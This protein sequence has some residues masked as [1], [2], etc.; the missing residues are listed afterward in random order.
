MGLDFCCLKKC[1]TQQRLSLPVHIASVLIHLCW[2]D[3][4]K[5][6]SCP[7]TIRPSCMGSVLV[8]AGSLW[9]LVVNQQQ[10]A[11]KIKDGWMD[12]QD[13]FFH[14]EKTSS[15]GNHGSWLAQFLF[16]CF[17]TTNN[18]LTLTHVLTICIWYTYLLVTCYSAYLHT[19]KI[20]SLL[21]RL[22]RWNPVST[23][24]GFIHNQ[25]IH[26]WLPMDDSVG[27]CWFILCCNG[28]YIPI[29]KT[30]FGNDLFN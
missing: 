11:G 10:P 9:P 25:I 21:D 4:W 24:L 18:P 2:G 14:S 3:Q 26:N 30:Y 28:N 5:D 22:P 13:T 29:I 27:I 15:P 16:I 12:E 8:G 19:Y 23:E 20:G 6:V 7:H 17:L 1:W